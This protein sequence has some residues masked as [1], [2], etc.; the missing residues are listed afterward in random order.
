MATGLRVH[1][2]Y[3]LRDSEVAWHLQL[4]LLV[5]RTSAQLRFQV[6][7]HDAERWRRGGCYSDFVMATFSNCEADETR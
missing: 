7:A 2:K 1:R 5:A 6:S 3:R 4:H